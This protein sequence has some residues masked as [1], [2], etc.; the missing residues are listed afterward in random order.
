MY[1]LWRSKKLR[2]SDSFSRASKFLKIMILILIIRFVAI[3]GVSILFGDTTTTSTSNM[4]SVQQPT[5]PG[6]QTG[7]Q[8][9]PGRGPDGPNGMGGQGGMNQGGGMGPGQGGMGPG[10]QGGM[11]QGGGMGPYG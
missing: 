2:D 7:M 1:L 9:P 4:N 11:N 5:V 3:E 6:Q 8:G 10:Q